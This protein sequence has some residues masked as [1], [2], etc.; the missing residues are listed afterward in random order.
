[1]TARNCATP[2]FSLK[3]ALCGRDSATALFF[4]VKSHKFTLIIP[5]NRLRKL[6]SIAF[7]LLMLMTSMGFYGIFLGLKLRNDAANDIQFDRDDLREFETVTFK[8]PIS[9]PYSTDDA[10]FERIDGKYEYNGEFFRLVKQRYANDTITI[11]CVKDQH[12]KVIENAMKTYVKTFASQ[13]TENQGAKLQI[14]LIK[15]YL[16]Q[17]FSLMSGAGGWVVKFQFCSLPDNE[18]AAHLSRVT[19][20]PEL[21]LI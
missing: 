19:Q 9:L 12:E 3:T 1:M 11:V 2:R 21:A 17:S 13:H 15:D 14:S 7:V 20:P 5:L 8:I 10:G 4:G 16:P 6:L 18:S